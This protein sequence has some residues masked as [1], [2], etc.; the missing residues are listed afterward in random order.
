MLPAPGSNFHGP[1]PPSPPPWLQRPLFSF[2][3]SALL[4]VSRDQPPT[5]SS[6]LYFFPYFVWFQNLVYPVSVLVYLK[7]E[8]NCLLVDKIGTMRQERVMDIPRRTQP[9]PAPGSFLECRDS[10]DRWSPF[11][12]SLLIKCFKAP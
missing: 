9:P 5:L 1:C 10:L 2:H 3:G 12:F 4:I 11:P 6:L 8:N 7:Y